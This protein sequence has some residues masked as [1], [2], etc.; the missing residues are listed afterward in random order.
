MDVTFGAFTREKRLQ[1][2]ITLRKFAKL[3]NKSPQFVSEMESG[4]SMPSND[5]L[6][7]MIEVLMIDSKDAEKLYDL[8]VECKPTQKVP[9]DVEYLLENNRRIVV[10]LRNAKDLDATDEEWADFV[11]RL[12]EN[13]LK[14]DE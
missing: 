11:R 5:T 2:K 10:A 4:Y 3:I 7:A 9:A 8:A 6:R 1:L 14:G 12:Q 13:R